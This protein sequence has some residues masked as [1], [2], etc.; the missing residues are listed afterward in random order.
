MVKRATVG[1]SAS[2]LKARRDGGR[3]GGNRLRKTTPGFF[4]S[5]TSK[6]SKGTN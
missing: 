2:S 5:S 4:P 1:N 6:E 3:T